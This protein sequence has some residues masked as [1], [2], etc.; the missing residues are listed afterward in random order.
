MSQPLFGGVLTVG[1]LF[2]EHTPIRTHWRQT[3]LKAPAT[4]LEVSVPIR[5]GR[6]SPSRSSTH[7]MIFTHA[8]ETPLG[9]AKAIPFQT[10]IGR[11]EDLWE[12]ALALAAAEGIRKQQ[13]TVITSWAAVGL[14]INP[15]ALDRNSELVTSLLRSWGDM[16]LDSAYFHSEDYAWNGG[17][18]SPIDRLGMLQIPWPEALADWDLILATPTRPNLAGAPSPYDISQSMIQAQYFEY[19]HQ[20]Y[21]HGLRTFQDA[22]IFAAL[23]QAGIQLPTS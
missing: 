7:T 6:L 15:L 8:V 12:Q 5:Y 10:P 4:S 20:N 19:F 11:W 9:V 18:K 17:E 1:S 21:L 22:E 23:A 13:P 2:W 16:F 14:L 3:Y